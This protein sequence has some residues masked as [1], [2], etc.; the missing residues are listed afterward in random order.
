MTLRVRIVAPERNQRS[1][2]SFP[3]LM[4]VLMISIICRSCV[5]AA[6]LQRERVTAQTHEMLKRHGGSLCA[7]SSNR[8]LGMNH[9]ESPCPCQ[10]L[11]VRVM[12][13]MQLCSHIKLLYG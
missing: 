4:V 7:L 5:T 11:P 3:L 8:A 10:K 2:T 9:D 1:I 13:L 6:T 12:T